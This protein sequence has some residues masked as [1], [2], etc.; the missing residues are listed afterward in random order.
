MPSRDVGA[1]RSVAGPPDRAATGEAP[2]TRLALACGATVLALASAAL[3]HNH[4]PARDEDF[5]PAAGDGTRAEGAGRRAGHRVSG[6]AQPW[7]ADWS[8][9]H[10][11]AERRVPRPR[12]AMLWLHGGVFL[13]GRPEQDMALMARRLACLDVLVPSVEHGADAACR[14]L[15]AGQAS[16][17][18]PLRPDTA[19]TRHRA[20]DCRGRF[21]WAPAGNRFDWRSHL[22]RDPTGVTNRSM[23]FPRRAE[24]GDM[25]P[26]WNGVGT[27]DLFHDE[28]VGDGR[29]LRAARVAC[30][31]CAV[32]G[33][34][35]GCHFL[36]PMRSCPGAFRMPWSGPWATLSHQREGARSNDRATLTNLSM[37]DIYRDQHPALASP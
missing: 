1:E 27:L 8:R 10:L 21:I 9:R 33:A 3:A 13:C 32:K 15:R 19:K 28:D 31:V 36:S 37:L 2:W 4:V 26:T 12:P 22:G 7:C 6:A 24:F 23:P 30:D 34:Y 11:R 17:P 18:T 16:L 29:R 25:P 35:H 14:G 20:R 5:P